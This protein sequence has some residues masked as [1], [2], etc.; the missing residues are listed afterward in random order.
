MTEC[1][2]IPSVATGRLDA[3]IQRVPVAVWLV[4]GAL[5]AMLVSLRFFSPDWYYFAPQFWQD[6]AWLLPEFGRWSST[7]PQLDD[8]FV[9]VPSTTNKVIEWRLLFP[10]VAYVT[11]M[12]EWLYLL[13]PALGSVL[14]LTW[15]GHVVLRESADRWLAL[16]AMALAATGSWHFVSLG[17][18]AYFD[19]WYMLA[20]M[21]VAFS[22][23]RWLVLAAVLLG[24][25]VD[26]RLI[27]ALPLCLAVRTIH[28]RDWQPERRQAFVAVCLPAVLLAFLYVMI[29]IAALGSGDAHSSSMIDQFTHAFSLVDVR[30]MAWGLWEAARAGYVLAFVFLWWSLRDLPARWA[31]GWIAIVLGSVLLSVMVAGDLS[32]SAAILWPMVM[33]GVVYL[34]QANVKQA[35]LVVGLALGLNLFLP[36]YHVITTD[37]K[38]IPPLDV[39]LRQ[40]DERRRLHSVDFAFHAERGATA[41]KAGFNEEAIDHLTQAMS[42]LPPSYSVGWIL[43]YR[44]VAHGRLQAWDQA[45]V[46]L[47]AAAVVSRHDAE[48]SQRI[49]KALE[50]LEQA[51]AGR[52]RPVVEKPLTAP[53]PW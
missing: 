23:S 51:R 8:P 33:G 42:H 30:L 19:S 6:P 16:L 21:M 31:A 13:L 45:Q 34:G 38:A 50:Q 43:Y 4:V 22:R 32:R 9:E 5:L 29:R 52:Q 14:C 2:E 41:V 48:L 53:A 36:A 7:L 24:P 28:F 37:Q 46:D 49:A 3:V 35:R 26:E 17:W 18:L 11:G 47:Q 20:A 15:I 40:L 25:W 39:A 1:G 44:A 10:I 27:L 12:P